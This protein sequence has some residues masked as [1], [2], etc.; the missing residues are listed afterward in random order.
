MNKKAIAILGAIFILIVVTLGVLI[1]SR[2]GSNKTA[3]NNNSSSG[4]NTNTTTPITDAG[5]SGIKAGQG[6]QNSNNNQN[7]TA[8]FFKLTDDQVI[9]PALTFDG[10]GVAYFTKQ[11]LLYRASFQAGSQPLQFSD[12]KQ[13][14]IEQKPNI[15]KVIWPQN[16]QSFMLEYNSFG[17]K[18]WEFYDN[19]SG[20]FLKLPAQV[21]S[22]SFLPTGDKIYYV[23]SSASGNDSVNISDPT[24]QN[25]KTISDI[26]DKNA[27]VYVS[28]DGQD[29]VYHQDPATVSGLDN[30][31]VLTDVD[32]KTWR[33]IVPTGFNN[34]VL[35]SPDGKK[36]LFGKRDPSTQLYQL[37]Y[38]DV[39]L[40]QASG[41][42][43]FTKPEKAVWSGDSQTIYAAVPSTNSGSGLTL[44]SFFKI[45]LATGQK[46]QY[47]PGSQQIDGEDLFLNQTNDKLLFRNAQDG[48]L[49]YLDL[50][51]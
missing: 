8:K 24:T 25:Y 48:G 34:S 39:L 32:G 20:Q 16:S 14:A 19:P 6:S 29:V 26:W 50:A 13:L 12:K 5:N 47:S 10:S 21:Y 17:K 44:D 38:Y 42:G 30:P 49:Y 35:W 43:L 33:K 36:F 40:G 3:S 2:S 45:N 15:S 22:L 1:Y 28:P 37:W 9:S 11:G 18:S 41:L 31:L 4:N 23:W 7:N 46:Q 27:V 51:Q